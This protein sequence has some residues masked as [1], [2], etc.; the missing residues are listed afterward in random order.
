[1]TPVQKRNVF[2]LLTDSFPCDDDDYD[3][4][5]NNIEEKMHHQSQL[6]MF[7]K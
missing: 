6:R 7:I 1:M 2:T 3:D 5:N 4:D